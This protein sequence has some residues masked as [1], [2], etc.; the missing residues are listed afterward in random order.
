[1]KQCVCAIEASCQSSVQ[2]A[3]RRF[4]RAGEPVAP[5][6]F[7]KTERG[8]TR[9]DGGSEVGVLKEEE[10]GGAV[11]SES[12]KEFLEAEGSAASW[13]RP[14]LPLR[15]LKGNCLDGAAASAPRESVYSKRLNEFAVSWCPKYRRLPTVRAPVRSEPPESACGLGADDAAPGPRGCPDDAT[16]AVWERLF[17]E[18]VRALA[19]EIL[20]H[21]CGDSCFKDSGAKVERICRHGFYYIISLADWRRRRRGKALRNAFFVG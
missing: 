19:A 16:A 2:S 3:P 18:D 1:M 9:F 15:D 4:G 20:V 14:D 10:A 6:P 21:I 11:L 17:A 7:S 12:Q 8:L 13:Q 5:L